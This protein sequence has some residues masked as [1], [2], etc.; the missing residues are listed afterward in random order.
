MNKF[1]INIECVTS[2]SVRTVYYVTRKEGESEE[3]FLIRK[4]KNSEPTMTSLSSEDHPEFAKLR[5]QLEELGFIKTERSWS[6][7]DRVLKSF[8][9]NDVKFSKGH[10]FCCAAAMKWTLEHG[11]A[12]L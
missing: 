10:K 12:S 9:L 3:D 1:Y 4:L 2:I 11:K 7:G 6:N 5:N 8:Y